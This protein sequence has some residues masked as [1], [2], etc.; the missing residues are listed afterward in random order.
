MTLSFQ[1]TENCSKEVEPILRALPEW[2]GIEESTVQYIKD[3][4]TMPTML[5][6]DGDEV[7]GFLTIHHHFPETAEMHCL[8]ILPKY[9]RTGIG[10]Q[11]VGALENHLKSEGVQLLQV[12][13]VSGDRA[14]QAYAKTRAFYLG[15]GFMPLEV[16]PTLW[17]E[18]NPC[19]LLVK[20]LA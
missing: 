20:H 17:D 2:F 6:K 16:F 13:T 19:L 5:V 18:A 12:K 1:I 3:A 4:D 15:V 14:C 9:H 7:I 10:K 8:G 11:L